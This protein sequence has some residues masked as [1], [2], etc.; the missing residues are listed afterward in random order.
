MRSD[1]CYNLF[2]EGGLGRKEKNKSVILVV[3]PAL[4]PHERRE[5]QQETEKDQQRAIPAADLSKSSGLKIEMHDHVRVPFLHS[6][7]VVEFTELDTEF[8][9]EPGRVGE[10]YGRPAFVQTVVLL[11]F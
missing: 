7:R 2:R 3:Y 6:V 9:V 5:A 8:R 10:I 11:G 1:F 4:S